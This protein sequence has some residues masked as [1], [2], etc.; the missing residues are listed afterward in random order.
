M[1]Q[2]PES[3]LVLVHRPLQFTWPG[4]GHGIGTQLPAR[5]CE[6][7]AQ[8]TP[9]PPQL[10]LS[11]EVS[12]QKPKHVWRGAMHV[13][14]HMPP[15]QALPT[16]QRFPHAPQFCGF[17]SRLTQTPLQLV[18]PGPHMVRHAPPTQTPAVPH[19]FPHAPQLLES[20]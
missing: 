16:A 20:L 13:P 8:R 11:V 7:V 9:Q 2:L 17:E 14:P 4:M 12:M 18:W 6:F 5:H 1:P 3:M 15:T 10:K 19:E